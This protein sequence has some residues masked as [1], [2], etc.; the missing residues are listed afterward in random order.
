MLTKAAC[1]HTYQNGFIT[2]F[3][4]ILFV[5]IKETKAIVLMGRAVAPSTLKEAF[6]M[7]AFIS[8]L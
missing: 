1:T 5:L 3:L 2:G 7:N 8:N 4:C 6:D